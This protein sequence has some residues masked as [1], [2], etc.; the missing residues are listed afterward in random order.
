MVG[1]NHTCLDVFVCPNTKMGVIDEIINVGVIE[2]KVNK[3]YSMYYHSL[4]LKSSYICRKTTSL[5]KIR[6]WK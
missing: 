3:F 1:K 6:N 4:L 2:R 5:I